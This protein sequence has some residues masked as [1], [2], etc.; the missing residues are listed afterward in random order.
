M[1]RKFKRLFAWTLSALL[2][3]G[4]AAAP[5][6]DKQAS[7]GADTES[8]EET[9]VIETP[10]RPTARPVIGLTADYQSHYDENLSMTVNSMETSL[11]GADANTRAEYPQLADAL[12]RFRADAESAS[13]EAY[14]EREGVF[15]EMMSDTGE[16]IA[17]LT[18]KVKTLVRRSDCVAVS[19]AAYWE[20][21]SGGAHGGYGYTTANFDSFTGEEIALETLLTDDGKTALNERVGA[22]LD[23]LYPDLAPGA[24]VAEYAPDDYAF[25][26]EP[27]GVTF[28]F[29][30][31]EIASYADGLLTV[32]LY[33]DR[34]A[35]LFTDDYKS[36]DDAWSVEI[37]EETP[38]R[39]LDPDG[40]TLR[41]V[42]VWGI[43]TDFDAD[44]YGAIGME[45]DGPE[46]SARYEGRDYD[47][48]QYG[49][50][51]APAGR[52]I[53]IIEET[54]FTL[55]AY[56]AHIP[57][58]NYILINNAMEN[59]AEAIRVYNLLGEEVG[60]PPDLTGPDD[61]WYPQPPEDMEWDDDWSAYSFYRTALTNPAFMP[62][63]SRVDLF[64]TWEASGSYHLTADGLER[65]GAFLYYNGFYE[66]TL[67]QELT[68]ERLAADNW[69]VSMGENLTIPAGSK[70]EILGTDGR[71]T[72]FFRVT[73]SPDA[74]AT[75]NCVFAL[76]YDNPDEW[77]RTVNGVEEEEIF[78]GLLYAG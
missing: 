54:A 39:F 13:Q 38:Y 14:Q 72:V 17:P 42:E 71:N 78:D 37:G 5:V 62:L 46:G 57:E 31:Y 51:T 3:A 66:L 30:P 55:R 26:L 73:D 7:G 10:V 16:I 64:G 28:W 8:A 52:N 63:R 53:A 34:D 69:L 49:D 23:S 60:E 48:S 20:E 27:D 15:E 74:P 43:I 65:D 19:V 11:P 61:F 56:F 67:K 35:D 33:F 6:A 47:D 76:F 18:G 9:E 77:P 24:M 75:V 2:L 58:G 22:E 36:L 25:T 12:D 21:Y 70:V 41:K 40:Q 59:D 44:W 1:E 4:C 32:K 68:V 29:N 50:W 45:F